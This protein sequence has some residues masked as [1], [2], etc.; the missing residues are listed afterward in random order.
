[1][2]SKTSKN[3]CHSMPQCP[4]CIAIGTTAP[5]LC[6]CQRR[7]AATSLV[8]ITAC[9]SLAEISPFLSGLQ[10]ERASDLILLFVP[11]WSLDS[12]Y[13]YYA[14]G[15]PPSATASRCSKVTPILSSVLTSTP[16]PAS[17][18]RDRW[19]RLL[20]HSGEDSGGYLVVKAM[21]HSFYS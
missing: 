5:C 2:K 6:H 10:L 7:R 16:S 20:I 1:M 18:S 13:I 3:H 8:V 4:S 15:T 21:K 12:H 11:V 19:M 9:S 17:S 14:S